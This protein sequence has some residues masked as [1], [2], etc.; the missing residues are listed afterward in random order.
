MRFKNRNEARLPEVNLIPMMDVLMTVLTFFIVISMTLTIEKGVE[1]ELPNSAD[2][3]PVTAAPEPLIVQ[4]DPQGQILLNN[5][6]TSKEQ[7]APQL[8][9]YLT[10][11]KEGFVVLQASPDLPYEDVVRL[12]GDLKEVG[13]DRVSLAIE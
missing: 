13:G 6:P 11:N 10:S 8:Q 9:S 1:V 4:L 3:A 5:Q 2:S 12:L 7:L